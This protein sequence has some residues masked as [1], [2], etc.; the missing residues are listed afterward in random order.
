V[1]IVSYTVLLLG[2]APV[3]GAADD[4][5]AEPRPWALAAVA[6]TTCPDLWTGGEAVDGRPRT[7]VGA[8]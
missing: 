5:P 1:I 3:R 2:I 7:V 4:V 6:G 8:G